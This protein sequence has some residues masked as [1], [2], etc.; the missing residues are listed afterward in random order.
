MAV[1]G[2]ALARV[3]VGWL[4]TSAHFQ[5]FDS[6]PSL[7]LSQAR[8]NHTQGNTQG[9]SEIVAFAASV[10]GDDDLGMKQRCGEWLGINLLIDE[11]ESGETC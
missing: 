2:H 3:D 4:L 1:C 7:H 10:V 5:N 9:M 8:R 6:A 11:L